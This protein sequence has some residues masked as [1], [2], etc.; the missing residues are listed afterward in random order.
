M[1]T[2]DGPH[3][4]RAHRD[5]TGPTFKEGREP[6]DISVTSGSDQDGITAK[7]RPYRAARGNRTLP[8]RVR[9][10]SQLRSALRAEP[11]IVG[12]LFTAMWTPHRN[13]LF[14]LRYSYAESFINTMFAITLR[15]VLLASASPI[16]APVGFSWTGG[17]SLR[18]PCLQN[19]YRSRIERT[20]AQPFDGRRVAQR[21]S[22]VRNG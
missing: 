8:D 16:A 12:N 7:A 20:V 9:F 2:F 10:I 11:Q 22:N 13:L 4:R 1:R 5:A 18:P 3:M 19:H 21:E 14:F 6:Q 17:A 15:R